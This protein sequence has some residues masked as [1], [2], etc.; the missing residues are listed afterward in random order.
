MRLN[1][2]MERYVWSFDDKVLTEVDKIRIKK[3]DVVRFNLI[4]ETMMHHPIHLHGHFFRVLNG[5][6]DYAPL[7]HTVNVPPMDKVIIE[8]AADHDK[9]WLFHCHN[10]YHM[11]SGMARVV[12]YMSAGEDDY[13]NSEFYRYHLNNGDPW[14]GFADTAL[15]SNML[16]GRLWAYNRHNGLELEYDYNYRDEYKLEVIGERRLTRFFSLYA[17]AEFERDDAAAKERAIVGAH[18]TLPLL[19]DAA[20]QVDSAGHVHLAL[21]SAL[22]LTDRL[23]FAWNWNTK[24]EYRGQFSYEI[25]KQLAVTSGYDSGF[26]FGAGLEFRY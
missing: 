18:Y 2:S 8:F 6:H 23:Q 21:E 9:D 5:E 16:V 19:V 25:S 7:K 24:A 20:L 17:G 13:R 11:T 22:R 15:Q 12:S 3:G 10:L 1:G 26:E 4:N 14:Y